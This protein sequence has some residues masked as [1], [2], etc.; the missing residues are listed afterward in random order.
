MNDPG[1]GDLCAKNIEDRERVIVMCFVAKGNE[2]P[3][4]GPAGI[5]VVFCYCTIVRIEQ[6]CLNSNR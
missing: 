6:Q 2:S 5:V 1:Y 3:E 4:A